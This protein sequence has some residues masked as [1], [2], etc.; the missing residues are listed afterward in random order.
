MKELIVIKSNG[1]RVQYDPIEI[2]NQVEIAVKGTG[3]ASIEIEAIINLSLNNR[4][5][6]KT[7]EIQEIIIQSVINKIDVDNDKY[8]LIAG[9]LKT[10]LTYR[11]GFKNTRIKDDDPD[12]L[13]KFLKYNKRFYKFDFNDI[14]DDKEFQEYTKYIIKNNNDSNLSITQIL[15]LES[16]Y[17]LKDKSEK[18]REYPFIADALTCL[19]LTKWLPKSQ[20][21]EYAKKFYKAVVN[22]DISLATPFKKNLRFGGNLSSCF[23]GETD[24]FIE[25]IFKSYKDI[26]LISKNG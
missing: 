17:L 16:K 2:R 20:R 5:T 10:Y 15:I 3:I 6:I 14:L 21:L 18:I 1:D 23:I 11:Q 9:R 8:P 12:I 24:D 13:S 4:K 22:N 25:S 19:G 7:S 26:A